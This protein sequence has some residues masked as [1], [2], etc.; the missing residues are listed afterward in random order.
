[1]LKFYVRHR[2][3]VEKIH[4]K[5]SFEQN[6]WLE[7]YICF[8]TQKRNKAK[9]ELG[10][11]FYKLLNNAFYGKTLENVRNRL[12]LEFIKRDDYKK[13]K[14]QQSNVPFAGIHKSYENCDSYSFRQDEVRLDKPFY[15]GFAILEVNKLH[16][17][18]TY[19][20]NIQP[21]FGQENL[22]LH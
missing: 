6:K 19:Y 9:N 22:Q 4:E 14:K 18:E 21:S 7:K 11:D 2:T 8:I 16:V 12:I 15:L 20:D 5:I 3:V 13:I 17:F 1:M 10:K